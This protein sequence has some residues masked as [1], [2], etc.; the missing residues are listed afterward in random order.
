MIMIWGDSKSAPKKRPR[1]ATSMARSGIFALICR[2]RAAQGIQRNS[3]HTSLFYIFLYIN[4]PLQGV[5]PLLRQ[6]AHGGLEGRAA[7]GRPGNV[8]Q[9]NILPVK[10]SYSVIG[11]AWR[12]TR[13]RPAASRQQGQIFKQRQASG[14][15]K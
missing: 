9:C 4:A 8:W 15:C 6:N 3:K 10:S 12:A 1:P 2:R 7:R 14:S 5:L 13:R 11:I